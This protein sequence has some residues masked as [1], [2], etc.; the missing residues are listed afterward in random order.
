MITN[1]AGSAATVSAAAAGGR[2]DAQPESRG[3]S[4]NASAARLNEPSSGPN[5]L[6][7][8]W[9]WLDDAGASATGSAVV[10]SPADSDSNL[11]SVED[12]AVVPSPKLDSTKRFFSIA[13]GSIAAPAVMATSCGEAE[14]LAVISSVSGTL[15]GG[16]SASPMPGQY[17]RSFDLGQS[18]AITSPA[19]GVW[20]RKN[21]RFPASLRPWCKG[22]GHP[23]PGRR[24]I[25]RQNQV[26]EGSHASRSFTK[27]PKPKARNRGGDEPINPMTHCGPAGPHARKTLE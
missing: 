17:H 13:E 22:S 8:A 2:A 25:S 20:E 3:P 1:G 18:P 23:T 21:A 5:A 10:D 7:G 27:A 16:C 11:A 9:S 24:A 26:M 14:A 19:A 12:V 15:P 4:S 6:L